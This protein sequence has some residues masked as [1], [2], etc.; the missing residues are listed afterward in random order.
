MRLR[1]ILLTALI[2]GC[3]GGDSATGPSSSYA[4]ISG[5]Y[6]GTIYASS[7][8][9]PLNATFSLTI[10]QSGGAI[11]GTDAV[12]GTLNQ[13]IPV[14]GTGTFTG[15]VATGNNPSVNVTTT[16]AGCPALHPQYSGS[17]DVA[18]RRLTMTG[19]MYITNQDCSIALTYSLTLIL[20]K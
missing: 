3:G 5:H 17:Y 18:N 2:V 15:T 8:S 12:V 19:P 7:Q 6:S 13:N 9:V 20:T 14:S 16:I 1:S 11:S 10:T 4:D